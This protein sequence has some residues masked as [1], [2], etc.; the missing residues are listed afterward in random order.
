M[1][2]IS[3]YHHPEG[4]TSA[5]CLE[6]VTGTTVEIVECSQNSILDITPLT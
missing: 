5:C 6:T 4:E 3:T 1:H 2:T